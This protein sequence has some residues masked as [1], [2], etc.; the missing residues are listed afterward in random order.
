MM[1]RRRSAACSTPKVRKAPK[2]SEVRI[3]L[4]PTTGMLAA[5]AK[6]LPSARCRSE[7]KGVHGLLLQTHRQWSPHLAPVCAGGRGVGCSLRSDMARW[8]SPVNPGLAFARVPIQR[9]H[10]AG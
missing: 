3:A 9:N 5:H 4:K 10:A 7:K 8:A 6:D 2:C 1:Y